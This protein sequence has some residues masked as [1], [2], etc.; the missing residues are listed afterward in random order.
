[1]SKYIDKTTK[2]MTAQI[3]PHNINLFDPISITGYLKKFKL[4]CSTNGVHKGAAVWMF[5]FFIEKNASE[6]LNAR[7]VQSAPSKKYS[8]SATKTIKYFTVYLQVVNVLSKTYATDEVIVETESDTRRALRN[9][10]VWRRSKK[11]RSKWQK[12]Y[13]MKTCMGSMPST[14]YLLKG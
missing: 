6:R 10:L 7:L 14:T 8:R 4:A 12:I 3:E 5:L 1:M 2:R 13:A 9:G 11:L